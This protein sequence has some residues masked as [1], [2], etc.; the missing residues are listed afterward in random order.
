M[1]IYPL[2]K[3]YKGLPEEWKSTIK[4][5]RS[6]F[7]K[8][9]PDEVDRSKTFD[10]KSPKRRL[11]ESRPTSYLSHRSGSSASSS[12]SPSPSSKLKSPYAPPPT[13][14]P[15]RLPP[16]P[17]PRQAS[18]ESKPEPSSR[19]PSRTSLSEVLRLLRQ[20]VTGED[21]SEYT[22]DKKIGQGA[23]G[24]VYVATH[25][26]S[27]R[28]VAI[29]QMKIAKQPRPELLVNELKVMQSTFHP[30]LVHAL[31]SYLIQDEEVWMVM[32]YM[33]GGP[34]SEWI[35]VYH[36]G[37]LEPHMACIVQACLSGVDHLH[38]HQIIHRDIKSDNVLMDPNG[39]VKVTDFGFSAKLISNQSKRATMVGTPYWMAPEV[40]KRQTYSFKIDIWSLG[41]LALELVDGEPP[42]LDI[43]PWRALQMIAEKGTPEIKKRDTISTF[44]LSFLTECLQL[45][46]HQRPTS[47]LLLQHPFLRLAC[48]S[49]VLKDFMNSFN[50]R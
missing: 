19:R 22:L 4:S 13:P 34:L 35:E 27:Q 16:T 36:E 25:E 23:S 38:R 21:A 31:A 14:L 29:K 39:G 43:E 46:S 32:E 8:R 47:E 48:S 15:S 2:F 5:S 7:A 44:F 18:N 28:R 30:H 33:Q 10:T 37:L 40:V 41:I 3:R 45:E 12:T 50:K 49:T 26:P 24:S 6:E 1:Y 20:T 17:P 42:Y 11:Q 9:R